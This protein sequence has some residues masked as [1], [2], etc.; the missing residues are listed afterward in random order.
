VANTEI[1]NKKD[2]FERQLTAGKERINAEIATFTAKSDE[3]KKQIADIVVQ[4]LD[5]ELQ[6]PLS[7]ISS[8]IRLKGESALAQIVSTTGEAL[9][10]L[11]RQGKD[12]T[13]KLTQIQETITSDDKI[14]REQRPALERLIAVGAKVNEITDKLSKI[15]AK[16][17][18][19][20]SSVARAGAQADIA[21]SRAT[22]AKQD[23]ELASGARAELVSKLQKINDGVADQERALGRNDARID[24]IKKQIEVQEVKLRSGLSITLDS[25]ALTQV[26]APLTARVTKAEERLD[27]LPAAS[28]P[29]DLGPLTERVTKAEERLDH[30][31][32]A[33]PPPDLGPL[34]T[35]V[36]TLAERVNRLTPQFPTTEAGLS[37]DQ[38]AQIQEALGFTDGQV[39]GKFGKNTRTAITQLRRSKNVKTTGP[40][41]AEEI[42]ELLASRKP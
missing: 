17:A 34:T 19:L 27:H 31:P 15:D 33:S 25:A 16:E 11:T 36:A 28:P 39:D 3:L 12:I 32:A 9:V 10:P 20:A 40:L 21:A 35:Q 41:T 14:L 18:T 8:Q 26:M 23:A 5:S 37:P 38:R 7:D 22:A 4:R 13:T 29:P 42:K 24:N 1:Q 30:L 2:D 6:A